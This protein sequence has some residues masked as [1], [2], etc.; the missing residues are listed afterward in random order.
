MYD[1]SIAWF[2]FIDVF[3]NLFL[4]ILAHRVM[5]E[6]DSLVLTSDSSWTWKSNVNWIFKKANL[7]S[8][9][10]LFQLTKLNKILNLTSLWTAK[11]GSIWDWKRFYPALF[12]TLQQINSGK[13]VM[14]PGTSI[15]HFF[16][17]DDAMTSDGFG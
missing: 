8:S 14:I 4:S 11:S 1:V 15:C 13:G 7:K 16:S 5:Q 6:M 10:I 12:F 3:Q 2:L 17:L 9:S